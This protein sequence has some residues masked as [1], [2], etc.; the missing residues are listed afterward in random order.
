MSLVEYAKRELGLIGGQEDEMQQLMNRQILEIIELFV[1]QEH[2]GF[3]ATYLIGTVSRLMSCK[4]LTP[5][6]GEEDEWNAVSGNLEQN[7]RCSSVFRRDCDNTTA[8]DIDGEV[9]SDDGGTTWFSRGGHGTPVI[10]PYT[11]PEAPKRIYL[12]K[13]KK[14]K[15]R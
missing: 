9:F 3:S 4:P 5:L 7:K 12:D 11:P 15:A 2:S 1:S 14:G 8:Y 13:G 6:T 10:F